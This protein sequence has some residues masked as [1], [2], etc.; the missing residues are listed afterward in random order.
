MVK[1]PSSNPQR[2]SNVKTQRLDTRTI[3]VK[4]TVPMDSIQDHR[5]VTAAHGHKSMERHLESRIRIACQQ[6]GGVALRLSL[7]S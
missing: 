1:N 6:T 4:N 3:S 7:F 5:M 2:N